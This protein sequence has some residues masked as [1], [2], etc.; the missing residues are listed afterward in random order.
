MTREDA[1]NLVDRWV[2]IAHG[3]PHYVQL[4]DPEGVVVAVTDTQLFMKD[5][6]RPDDEPRGWHLAPIAKAR[7]NQRIGRP[8]YVASSRFRFFRADTPGTTSA[9]DVTRQQRNDARRVRRDKVD[10]VR[11]LLAARWCSRRWPALTV[12]A[13]ERVICYGRLQARITAT[14]TELRR[15]MLSATLPKNN[16]RKPRRPCVPDD[17]QP[18]VSFFGRHQD[19]F[20]RVVLGNHAFACSGFGSA[21]NAC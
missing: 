7:F 19:L 16:R 20:G 8:L 9:K 17:D 5:P 4:H 21:A 18:R 11:G 13:V 14:G 6:Q 12:A 2:R 3:G 1:L 15:T 10:N